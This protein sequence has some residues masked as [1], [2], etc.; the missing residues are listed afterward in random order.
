MGSDL[1]GFDEM[2]ADALGPDS[3]RERRRELATYFL[4]PDVADPI[5][6]FV[7]LVDAAVLAQSEPIVARRVERSTEKLS[8]PG[9][10]GPDVSTVLP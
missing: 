6:H 1:A 7:G 10:I 9:E 8:L 5:G 2:L 3:L 4:G